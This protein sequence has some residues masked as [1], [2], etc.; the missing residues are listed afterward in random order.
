MINGSVSVRF[1]A[2]ILRGGAKDREV[3]LAPGGSVTLDTDGNILRTARLNFYEPLDWLNEEVKPYI[4]TGGAEYPLGVFIPSTPARSSTDGQN[5]WSV[6]A[7]DRTIILAEDGFDEPYYI[8]AGTGFISAVE[9]ILTTA[10]TTTMLIA[11]YVDTVLPADRE[12]EI[13]TTKLEAINTL[14]SE[15]NYN[16]IYCDAEGRFVVEAYSEPS[17]ANVDISYIADKKSLIALDTTTETDYYAMPNVWISVCSNPDMDTDYQSVYVN[18]NPL[19]EFSTVQRGRRI[20]SEIY[21]PEQIASQSDL[22]AYIRRTAYEKM[23]KASETAR[24]QTALNSK[25]GRAND[26]A[27]QHPDVNGVFRESSWTIPL[28]IGLMSHTARRVVLM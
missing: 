22:D 14:L 7:Y 4:M 6:E 26:I 10:G 24:F 18:D 11:D 27:I 23:L 5:T 3:T 15:I 13:G 1:R 8:A 9:A 21:Q 2:D 25:H 16:P 12:F 19:S 20:L 17:P 28:E